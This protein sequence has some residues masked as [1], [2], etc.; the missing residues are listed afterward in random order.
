MRRGTNR[1][2][3]KMVKLIKRRR[4]CSSSSDSRM[5]SPERNR[6][7]NAGDSFGLF[8]PDQVRGKATFRGGLSEYVGENVAGCGNGETRS[9]TKC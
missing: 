7:W 1:I 4:K 5:V 6:V 3:N 8:K 9:T 2:V